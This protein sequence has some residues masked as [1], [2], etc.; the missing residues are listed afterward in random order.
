MEHGQQN[1]PEFD[2]S[3]LHIGVKYNFII[4]PIDFS[5]LSKVLASQGYQVVR[6]TV[7]QGL[8]NS[9]IFEVEGTVA[10][11]SGRNSGFTGRQASIGS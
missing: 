5:I 8:V 7:P 2:R 1:E 6:P 11:K 4:Y 9:G 3:N 10:K